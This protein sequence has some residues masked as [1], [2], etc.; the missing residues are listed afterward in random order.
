[1]ADDAFDAT[2]MNVNPGGKQKKMKDTV[3]QG[4]VQKMNFELGVPKGMRLILQERG[5]DVTGMG[6][7]KMRSV[8]AEMGRFKHERCLVEHYLR[9]KGHIAVFA[10]IPPE[11]NPIERVWAQLKRYTKAHCIQSL[12]KTSWT[13][14]TPSP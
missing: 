4:K 3:W 9:E 1:M 10:K 13:P 5:V 2:K 6:A 12:Q 11:L 7:E 14:T 8:L